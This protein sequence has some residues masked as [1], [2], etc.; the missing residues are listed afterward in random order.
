[1]AVEKLSAPAV[2]RIV[3]WDRV[4][5]GFGLRLTANGARSWVA[6]YRVGGRKIMETLGTVARLPRVDDARTLARASM[7]K[8]ATGAN[9]VAEKRSAAARSTAKTVAAAVERYLD[10]CDRNLRAKTAGEWRRIF[11]HDVLPRWGE[12]PIGEIAKA[13]VL[14]L[15]NDKAAN[16]ERKRKDLT[17]GASV[18]AGKTLSRLRTFFGW[19]VAN[20]L[21]EAD[22]TIGVRKPA[23]EGQRDRVLTDDEVVAFWTATEGLGHPFGH[24]F[25][26]LLLTAQRESE[27]AGLRWSELGD[28]DA[29]RWEIP[30]N[31]TKNRKAHTVH[32]SDLAIEVLDQVPRIAEQDLLFSGSGRTPVSGFSNA[33]RR[34]DQ[35]IAQI[36][37]AEIPGWVLHDLRR[38]ATTGL[39][40][41][42]IAPHVADK[43]LNHTAG[44][45]RGTALVYNRFEYFDER[46]AALEA[47]GRYIEG[48]IGR[49]PQNVVPMRRAA[50]V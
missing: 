27:V 16:R 9:P 23:K 45:I 14:E 24:L 28:L 8:A 43:I 47:W 21:V 50:E 20:D 1:M 15:V 17:E 36:S 4:C 10:H 31:R 40:R 48:L 26:L 32:L 6:S 38:T 46:K 41:L 39:A 12:R 3:Y 49:E 42:G 30:T 37:G 7:E 19:A 29:R 5:P 11:E 25:R 2:G 18:Q 13:D 33:K 35:R 34:L 44:T 22:P